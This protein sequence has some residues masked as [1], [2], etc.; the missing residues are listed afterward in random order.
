MWK[1]LYLKF[2][3]KYLCKWCAGSIID[4]SVIT[5]SELAEEKNCFNKKIPRQ[6]KRKKPKPSFKK[7]LY[8]T[9]V[10]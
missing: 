10:F 9:C 4:D 5:S 3:F 6:F 7:T 8:F 1:K 2:C